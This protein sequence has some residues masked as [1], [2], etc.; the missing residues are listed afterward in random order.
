MS[1][2][3]LHPEESETS[4]SGEDKW[5]NLVTTMVTQQTE[6]AERQ[7]DRL[8]EAFKTESESNRAAIKSLEEESRQG[9]GEVRSVVNRNTIALVIVAL[10]GFAAVTAVAAGQVMNLNLSPEG[11]TTSAPAAP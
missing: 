4:E 6:A 9:L 2:A 3:P 5:L 11:V 10:V 1:V 8:V 7:T